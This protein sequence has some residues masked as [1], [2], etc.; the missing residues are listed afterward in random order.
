MTRRPA[1]PP[2]APPLA[3]LA[4]AAALLLG[5]ACTHTVYLVQNPDGTF[6]E[7]AADPFADADDTITDDGV[8]IELLTSNDYVLIDEGQPVY[9]MVEVHG[10]ATAAV[11][12]ARAPMNVALVVDRSGSMEGDKLASAKRAAKGLLDELQD[13]DRVALVSYAS[14][15]SVELPAT[16]VGPGTRRALAAAVERLYAAGG[17]HLSGGLEA[18]AQEIQ[19]GYRGEYLNRVILLSDGNANIGVTDVRSLARVADGLRERGVTVTTMGLGFDYNEEL[20]TAVALSGGGNYYYVDRV[21]DLAGFFATELA[22]LGGTVTRDMML[23]LEL[24]DGVQVQDVYGYRHEQRGR[25]LQVHLNS[26]SA[27]QKRRL[28]LSLTPPRGARAGAGAGATLLAR[29]RVSYRNEVKKVDRRFDLKPLTVRYTADRGLVARS[30][31]RKV[32]EK[33]EAVR[34]A[35]ARQAALAHLDRGDRAGAA[36]VVQQRLEHSRRLNAHVKSKAVAGQ[37]G[38]LEGLAGDVS[39]APAPSSPAYKQMRKARKKEAFDMDMY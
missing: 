34:N 33:L 7:V 14:D 20:M 23:H 2:V 15:V 9:V 16:T 8:I 35:Q 18:G 27:G 22:S 12:A 31:N 17:T 21:S 37:I 39:T 4:L 6:T 11:A 3:A 36:R 38:E 29:P 13:G 24:P 32:V 10:Q 19:R 30:F 28:L 5:A 25:E 26:L 1:R